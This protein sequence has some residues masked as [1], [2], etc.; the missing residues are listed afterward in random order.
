[1]A[2]KKTRNF[3]LGLQRFL[4]L[5]EAGWFIFGKQGLRV[6]PTIIPSM[7]ASNQY[8]TGLYCV[9]IFELRNTI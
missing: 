9:R 8:V 5:I 1:M 3:L 2:H 7:S 6:F 4:S